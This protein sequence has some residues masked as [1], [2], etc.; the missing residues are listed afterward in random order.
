MD[1]SDGNEPA[2]RPL[3]WLRAHRLGVAIVVGLLLLYTLAG[4]LLVPY[5]AST[6]A[7]RYVQRNLGRQLTIGAVS[8][9][10]FTFK[11][12]I[13]DLRLT[14]ADGS[15]LVSFASFQVEFSAVASLLHRAWTLSE[16]RLEAPVVTAL[17]A[18]DGSLNLTKLAPPSAPSPKPPPKANSVPALRIG[19]LS[20][21]AGQVHFQDRSRAQPFSATLSP[22]EFSLSD[23][24]TQLNFENRY[25]F[26]AATGAGEQ[27]DWSGEFAVQPLGSTG[28]FSLS[29]IKVAT[30]ASYL[31]DALPF[32]LSSG[33]LDLKGSYR[34]VASGDSSLAL[35]LPSLKV[36]SLAISPKGPAAAGGSSPWIQL[37][38]LDVADTVIALPARTVS[39]AQVK[40]EKPVLQLWREADGSLNLLH[41]TSAQAA[42]SP[43]T[44]AAAPAAAAPATDTASSGAAFKITLAR[45]SID[46]ADIEAEDR[47][48]K[49][50]LQLKVAPLN[51]SVEN[52]SSDGTQPLK[53]ALDTGLGTTGKL[54]GDG[55]LTL[56]PLSASVNAEL[57][58]FD[59]PPLQPY[60]SQQTAMTLYRGRL[61]AKLQLAYN[62]APAKGQAHL[63]L[64]GGVDLSDLATRDNVS[65]AD[66]ITWKALQLVGIKFQLD[67]NALDVDQVRTVGAY[68]RVIIGANGSLN[69]AEILHPAGAK[70]GALPTETP[71]TKLADTK[72]DKHSRKSKAA[73]PEPP[74]AAS[75][76]SAPSMPIRIRSVEIRD[77][78]ADFT[79]HTVEPNFSVA[80]LG[81]HGTVTGLSS[82]PKSRAQVSI[83]GSV[84]RYAPVQIKGQLAPFAPTVFTDI[85]MSFH[86]IEL[87]TFNPYSGKFAGYSIAQGKLSTDIHYHIDNRKLQAS[88]H[89][90]IDQLEFGPATESKQAVSL[91]VKLAVALLKDRNGVI[92]LDLPVNGSIDDPQFKLGPII[93]KVFVNLI[94]KVVTAPFAALG[95]L[96]GGGHE[97]SYID[98]PAGAAVVADSEVQKLG[99][100]S[101]ALVERPQL[102]LDIPL[103]AVNASDD[104]ALAHAALEQAVS[105]LGEAA[106]PNPRSGSGRAASGGKPSGPA[107]PR[108]R[109]LATIYKQKF[110]S[111]PQYPADSGGADPDA[112]RIAWLEQELLPQFKA[113]ADQRATLGRARADAVQAAVLADKDLPPERVFLT[114]RESG[115]GSDTQVRMELKLQ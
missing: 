42:A 37:P 108:L 19:A 33:S 11:T 109:A 96:F 20:V 7:I 56:S 64:S 18:R 21:S 65:N 111:D 39:I 70:A 23:F 38:E 105:A 107:S 103:H 35:T 34:V 13:R 53:F 16:V 78:A 86:N 115:A 46:A 60:L 54:H 112:A 9:N 5:L 24:R 52:Y 8:F 31:G 102:K 41:L 32:A 26:A 84:D 89:V 83:D 110:Q 81:L 113:T 47:S 51:L 36:H 66:F 72:P 50:V 75:T 40:L 2:D 44:P 98:F 73:N 29:S 61:G 28:D 80:M 63:K 10:P 91:P 22:I 62:G 100:L 4:F 114:D 67:P 95:S 58:E 74:A 68:G 3:R 55:S 69:V 99:K 82:D 14:E 49:P 106:A 45:L 48:V 97:L 59:L 30:I 17:V 101:K 27:L 1:V 57:K 71:P 15:P 94:T 88:H 79:D 6:Q 76:S 90:V 43:A 93:W 77:G 12:V 104:A 85:G 25:H 87:T 92:D